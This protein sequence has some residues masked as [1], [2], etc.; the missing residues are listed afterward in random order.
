MTVDIIIGETSYTNALTNKRN[1]IQIQHSNG[2]AKY[3]DEDRDRCHMLLN[4][5]GPG[6]LMQKRV[7]MNKSMRIPAAAKTILC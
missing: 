5:K 4:Y 1:F 6:K 2:N 7:S 3:K